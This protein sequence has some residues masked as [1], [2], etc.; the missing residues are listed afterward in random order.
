[1]RRFLRKGMP[2]PTHWR[3]IVTGK[4]RGE[5]HL[6][7][8]ATLA[9]ERFSVA[10]LDPHLRTGRSLGPFQQWALGWTGPEPTLLPKAS[11]SKNTPAMNGL[12]SNDSS[13]TRSLI[14]V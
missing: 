11:A 13:Y 7:Q 9:R 6:Y 1:M 3:R 5:R 14:H 10:H 12:T 2:T 4:K 8:K